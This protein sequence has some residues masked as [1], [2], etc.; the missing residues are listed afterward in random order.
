MNPPYE[1]TTDGQDE[2]PK[3]TTNPGEGPGS[4]QSRGRKPNVDDLVIRQIEAWQMDTEAQAFIHSKKRK[5]GRK[6]D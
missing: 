5:S 3:R 6:G 2:N 4:R 1:K